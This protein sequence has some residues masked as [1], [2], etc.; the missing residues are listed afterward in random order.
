MN[1]L[2]SSAV[3]LDIAFFIIL[4][5]GLLF[6]VVR[7]FVKCVF[8][9]AGLVG[10]FFLAFTFCNAFLLLLDEWF[11]LTAAISSAV[12][13]ETIGGWLAIAV[14][15]LILLI[16]ANLIAWILG[17][18]GTLLVDR[19]KAFGVINKILGGLWGLCEAL[20]IIFLVL[21]IF[22][23]INSDAIN[24]FIAESQ[25]VGKIYVSEWFQWAATFSFLE[26]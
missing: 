3:A 26:K 11:G 19:V 21:M 2:A 12:N 24:A 1:L 17:A 5:I 25:I 18:L 14:S 22:N 7:G 4:G 6:G 10:S 20:V 15:F 16:G 13:N 23:W 8:K 9:W